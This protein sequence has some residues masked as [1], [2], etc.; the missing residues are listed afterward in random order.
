[1]LLNLTDKTTVAYDKINNTVTDLKSHFLN[2]CGE[3]NR[4]FNINFGVLLTEKTPILKDEKF[5]KVFPILSGATDTQLQQLLEVFCKIRNLNAH[6]FLSF[7]IT[8]P[9]ELNDFLSTLPKPEYEITVDGKLTVFG[10][11]YILSLLSQ[12]YQLT[13][14][15]FEV[16]RNK[17]FYKI[18]K[19]E[20]VDILTRLQNYFYSLCGKG[21]PTYNTGDGFDSLDVQNFNNTIKQYL[22]KVFFGIEKCTLKWTLSSKSEPLFNYL[23]YKNSPFKQHN[24]LSKKLLRLR[25]NW[26]DGVALFDEI[27]NNGFIYTVT[28]NSV[29]SVLTEL[30]DLLSGEKDYELVVDSIKEFGEKLYAFYTLRLIEISYKILDSTL[31]ME[32]KIEDRL[33]SSIKAVERIK[34]AP[35]QFFELAEKLVGHSPVTYT[36][37]AGR[38]GDKLPRVFETDNLKI[39][40]IT[41]ANPIKIGEYQTSL[42]K[43][44]F[45]LVSVDIEKLKLINGISPCDLKGEKTDS[46]SSKISIYSVKLD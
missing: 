1:M 20:K 36:I 14:F 16:L 23:L 38:F 34:Q 8:V 12:K 6:L 33:Q 13:P 31:F 41:S 10:M 17:Y 28:L 29:I 7:P 30:K 42:T 5:N 24:K 32:D 39:L 11:I 37:N 35:S 27:N 45:A 22:T 9:T 2:L 46:F 3:I 21:K 44:Y 25:K 4:F 26:I 15:L 40:K 43:I 18:V 19:Q